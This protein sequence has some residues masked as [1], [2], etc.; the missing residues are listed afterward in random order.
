MPSG[1]LF[2][3]IP[4]GGA[5]PQLPPSP[6]S[7][8]PRLELAPHVDARLGFSWRPPEGWLRVETARGVVAVDGVTWDYTA[9][10]QVIVER[11]PTV[12]AY[13]ERYGAHYLRRGNLLASERTQ[14]S[15]RP[16]LRAL[17]VDPEGRFV[18]DL[19]FA[20]TGDGRVVVVVADCPAEMHDAYRP[21]FDAALGSLRI[22]ESRDAGGAP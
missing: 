8:P 5:P 3:R 1:T 10:F 19:T 18:E 12:E 15:G 17:M 7:G 11:Y 2:G 14:V 4:P 6:P 20:E 16:A 13:L 9:S 22:W 21:W